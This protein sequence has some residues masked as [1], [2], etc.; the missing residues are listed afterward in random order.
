[1]NKSIAILA[2][3]F[4]FSLFSNHITLASGNYPEADLCPKEKPYYAICTDSMHGLEGWHGKRCY[5][6]KALAQQ[7]AEQH[8]KAYH[9]GNMRWTGISQRR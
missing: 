2:C 3:Y 8:A 7:D 6:N 5:A 9:Q 4:S 1:M